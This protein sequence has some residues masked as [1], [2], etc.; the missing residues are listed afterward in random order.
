MIEGY[1]VRVM[2][3]FI[4]VVD[5]V[6]FLDLLFMEFEWFEKDMW[7]EILR[8]LWVNMVDKKMYII[9]GIGVIKQWE[10]FGFDYFFFQGIDE[11][12]CY[13]EICVFIGIMMF[14]E[15]MLY[16]DFDLFYV[17]I[18]E[19]C[20]YNNVMMFMSMDGKKFIYDNQFVSLE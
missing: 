13:V 15:R 16:I 6:V 17:D 5:F 11:G 3:L 8:R 12:G 10:G 7:I 19:F 9:G 1:S 4:V 20:F 18:M 2:Y 14:V